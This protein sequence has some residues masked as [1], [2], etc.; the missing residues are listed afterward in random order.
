MKRT[1]LFL[2]CLLLVPMVAFAEETEKESKP[3]RE[4][5]LAGTD[6]VTNPEVIPR[7]KVLPVFPPKFRGRG[8]VILQIVVEVNGA[9]SEI[10]VIRCDRPGKGLEKSAANAVKQWR[11][12]P[13]LK[14]GKPVP[15]YFTVVMDFTR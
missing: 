9:V 15:V 1:A 6:G 11:Y 2:V 7:S 8:Q 14:D 4:I 3:E 12:K 5:F 13:A 10:S